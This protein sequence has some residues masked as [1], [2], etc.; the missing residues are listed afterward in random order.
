MVSY[1]AAKKAPMR[2]APRVLSSFTANARVIA[3]TDVKV[4][5]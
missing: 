2:P 3:A 4:V 1:I 5:I